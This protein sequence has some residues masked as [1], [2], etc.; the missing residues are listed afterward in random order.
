[1]EKY[2]I[3]YRQKQLKAPIANFISIPT[4]L[5]QVHKDAV[6]ILTGSP[7]EPIDANARPK[8]RNKQHL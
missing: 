8:R 7:R 4:N 2:H 5:R 6:R 3:Y 1:M